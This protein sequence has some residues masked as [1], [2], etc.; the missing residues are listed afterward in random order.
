MDIL[1]TASNFVKFSSMVVEKS[2]PATF[3]DGSYRKNTNLVED[4]EY[5]YNFV[6]Y[7]VVKICSSVTKDVE[8]VS[9]NQRPGYHAKIYKII[10]QNVEVISLVQEYKHII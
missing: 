7:Q 8:D 5:L 1:V 6:S 10:L 4:V 2:I 3:A 9:A